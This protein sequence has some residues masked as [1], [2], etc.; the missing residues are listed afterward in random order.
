MRIDHP[1]LYFLKMTLFRYC[2]FKLKLTFCDVEP[3]EVC[4]LR[5]FEPSSCTRIL[6]QILHISSVI[7]IK[8]EYDM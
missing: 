8:C 2:Y 4:Y 3:E 5:R 6:S 1:L 7:D